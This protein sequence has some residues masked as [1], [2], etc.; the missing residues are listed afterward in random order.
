MY[1]RT[2]PAARSTVASAAG[3]AGTFVTHTYT[4]RCIRTR[5][6]RKLSC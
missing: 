4:Y 1:M 3:C 2:R 5:E 6:S